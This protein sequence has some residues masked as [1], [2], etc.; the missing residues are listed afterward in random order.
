M[1]IWCSYSALETIANF[2]Q[3]EDNYFFAYYSFSYGT[4]SKFHTGR[5]LRRQHFVSWTREAMHA[6]GKDPQSTLN[7][8]MCIHSSISCPVCIA[9]LLSMSI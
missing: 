8:I 9:L 7:L 1:G 6:P 2:H 5:R 3:H 4:F